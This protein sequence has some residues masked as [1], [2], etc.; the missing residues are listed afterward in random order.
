MTLKNLTGEH[1]ISGL[2]IHFIYCIKNIENEMMYIGMT[3][4]PNKRFSTHLQQLELNIHVN[5]K[6]QDDFNKFGFKNF[7]VSIVSVTNSREEAFSKER[8][9]INDLK[10]LNKLYNSVLYDSDSKDEKAKLT[11][12]IINMYTQNVSF[13]DIIKETG[14]GK[15]KIRNI[16][17][18]NGY[19]Q[20]FTEEMLKLS[21]EFIFA[22]G[23]A[24]NVKDVYQKYKDMLN[25]WDNSKYPNE[26]SYTNELIK[27]I[28]Q[29]EYSH[30]SVLK[31]KKVRE[32]QL[33]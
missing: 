23:F 1:L 19:L 31:M 26:E 11:H 9:Y 6:L 28:D 13:G 20:P 7:V 29:L 4:D 32:K 33:K 17:Q 2:D 21:R 18:C 10:P 12:K 5:K 27:L 25:R 3:N 16:L 15:M 30:G 22:S 24:K 14:L 8:E